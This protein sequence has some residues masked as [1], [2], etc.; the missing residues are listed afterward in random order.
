MY[1]QSSG[2]T[3]ENVCLSVWVDRRKRRQTME[4]FGGALTNSAAYVIYN[5]PN[6]HIIMRDL[7]GQSQDD[8]G[9]WAARKS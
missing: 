3:G 4:G 5:S 1:D 7:F 6:R 8:L 9:R 2:L